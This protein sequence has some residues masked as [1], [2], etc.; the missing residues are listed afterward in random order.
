VA[1]TWV[2]EASLCR[3][4]FVWAAL[5]CPGAYACDA[6]GRGDA[7]LGRLAARVERLPKPGE[8]CT[9]LGWPLG[10]EGRKLYAGTALFVEEGDV[11]VVA[12]ATWIIPRSVGP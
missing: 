3:S 4:E 7:L 10:E 9:V 11:I 12:R 1:A 6:V 8:R 2:P 5:D